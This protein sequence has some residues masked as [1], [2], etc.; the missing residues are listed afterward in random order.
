MC[1]LA[2]LVLG[3]LN[4]SIEIR[5]EECIAELLGA[6]GIRAL[7]DDHERGVLFKRHERIDRG[8]AGL[9]HGLAWGRSQVSAA[10]NDSGEMLGCC[11]AATTND[12]HSEFGDESLMMIGQSFWGEVVMHVSVDNTRQAG[13]W[14]A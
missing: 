1:T 5:I 13:I 9:V 10:F 6:V 2:D 7:A 14:N 12:I 8:C 11:S 3:H 4:A